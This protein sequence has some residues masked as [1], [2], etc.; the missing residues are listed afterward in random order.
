MKDEANSKQTQKRGYEET[1][2]EDAWGS[3]SCAGL[4]RM[5]NQECIV[6]AQGKMHPQV[7]LG[8]P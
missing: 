8:G 4:W 1:E 5:R 6:L 7:R 3:K 2:E